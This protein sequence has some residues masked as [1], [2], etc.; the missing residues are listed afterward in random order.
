[1]FGVR[2]MATATAKILQ[3]EGRRLHAFKRIG[4]ELIW[5]VLSD[6][7][8]ILEIANH[9]DA[10]SRLEDDQKGVGSTDS[11]GGAQKMLI[12]SE[13]GVYEIACTS[14]K[15]IAKR[16]K[17]WL[18]REVLPEI[19]R[20]GSYEGSTLPLDALIGELQYKLDLPPPAE[21][22]PLRASPSITPPQAKPTSDDDDETQRWLNREGG[23]RQQMAPL[24]AR[25][26]QLDAECLAPIMVG[27]ADRWTGYSEGRR[28]QVIHDFT[29]SA[30]RRLFVTAN[31]RS[32]VHEYP[33]LSPDGS[34]LLLWLNEP[35]PLTDFILEQYDRLGPGPGAAMGKATIR[36]VFDR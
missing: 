16:F 2:T 13:D 18:Y 8:E 26:E 23:F 4:S 12:V 15:P 21:V 28:Y 33:I 5:F 14:R 20:T 3:F 25:Q 1:M 10:A 35:F 11:L 29:S 24:R 7:C 34:E 30:K 32:T 6:V 17:R 19:R 31:Y 27:G 36:H 9:R 22:I